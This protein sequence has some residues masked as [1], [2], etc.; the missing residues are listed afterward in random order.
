MSDRAV[1]IKGGVWTGISTIVTMSTQILRLV[2]LTRFLEKSDFGIVSIT[3]MVIGLCVTFTDLGFASAIM[4]KKELSKNEF[5]SLYWIQFF[6]FT[7]IYFFVFILAK[8]I[9]TFYKEQLLA[10]L[11]PISALSVLAQAV[12]KLYDSVLLKN[13]LFKS[14]MFRNVTSNI[15]SLVLAWVLAA[16]GYG[17]YS[18]IY[19]TL[20]QIV[21]F[22]IW[23]F[24]TGYKIQKL[25]FVIKIEPVKPLI[26]MGLY[27][28]G[29]HILD[30]LSSKLDVMIMG[31]LIGMELLGVY[32][33]A[34]E[35]VVKFVTLIR[36]V[37][38]RVALPILTNSNSDDEAV[39][40]RFLS[41]TR[42]VAYIC[43]PVCLSVSIFSELIVKVL[44]GD[45]YV[46][47]IPIVSILALTSMCGSIASF[48]DMLGV[49]KGRTDLNFKQTVNRI[50]ITTPI[51]IVTSLFGL[52]YVVW[53][54]V[55]ITIISL[56]LFWRTVL[57][58]TYPM[59]FKTYISQF[60]R[61]LIVFAILGG[62]MG[63]LMWINPI[64][65]IDNWYFQQ[66]LYIVLYICLISF[67][68]YRFLYD[69]CNYLKGLIGIK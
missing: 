51:V 7:L 52:M 26:K 25:S 8:P 31:K 38:S 56:T 2:I 35:I 65:S 21:F 11:I 12:G 32:D 67:S 44:Y 37:V 58:N 28:T 20:F 18:L 43:I 57:M 64:S 39:K 62:F 49:A 60:S 13:Y 29:T 63:L 59:S 36:T 30:Y 61:Y 1:A 33:L 34:K 45:K 5:S 55:L 9:A 47:A 27:Q 40:K 54:Q 24:V 23:N 17:V 46:D 6:F 69:D 3:N 66:V 53:G 48:F 22:N 16:K 50:F 10:V 4:Y 41:I 19:S 68:V 42:V 15:A 14:L